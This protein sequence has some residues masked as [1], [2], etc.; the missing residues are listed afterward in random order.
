MAL[1]VLPAPM[2]RPRT[3]PLATKTINTAVGAGTGAL[4][5]ALEGGSSDDIKHSAII[6]GASGLAV[7]S[8]QHPGDPHASTTSKEGKPPANQQVGERTG[9]DRDLNVAE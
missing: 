6:G 1:P 9:V 3:G 2:R 4:G 7:G 5:T 8:A